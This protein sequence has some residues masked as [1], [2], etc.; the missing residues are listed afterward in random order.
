MRV[1]EMNWMQVEEQAKRDDRCVLPL[2]CVEQ[3]AYL[4]LATDAILA[5]KVANDA[6]DPLGLPVFPVLA[7]GM[8]PSFAAYPGTVSIRMSTYVAL[9]ED[10]LEG[11][12]RS[13]F[14]R[15]VLVN[16][17]GGNNPVMTFCT[18]WMGKRTDA[19]VKLHDWWAGPRFQAAVKAVDPAAS[20]AS[21]ME[22]FPW[23]RLEGVAMPDEVK[24]PF[25]RPLYLASNPAKKREILGDGNF[26]GR[27]QRS[28]NE[29]L[30]LWQVGVEETRAVIEEGW[31]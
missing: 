20:H 15:I 10:M 2:G 12:Y 9:I 30:S 18:E 13:G 11:F 23:T 29:M 6:A 16:G 21:W 25:D 8:T 1:A 22:N 5:E 7:Y 17:H 14:R 3:H 31:P 27:Y 28:D 26:W 24:P 19:S 4:S